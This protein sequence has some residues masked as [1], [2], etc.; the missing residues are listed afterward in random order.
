MATSAP[1][2]ARNTRNIYSLSRSSQ[3]RYENYL[4]I[5]SRQAQVRGVRKAGPPGV[6]GESNTVEL[7]HPWNAVPHAFGVTGE[8]CREFE[9]G[10]E[11]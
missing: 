1:S 6:G 4:N 11:L 2:E 7:C 10:G 9:F 8:L 5:S 3:I